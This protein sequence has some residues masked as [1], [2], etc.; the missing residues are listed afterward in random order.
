MIR[1]S[2]RR[3]RIS[4]GCKT[5]VPP[6]CRHVKKVLP[7][8]HPFLF[9]DKVVSFDAD[10]SAITCKKRFTHSE[11]FFPGHFPGKPIVPGGILIEAMAQA[12]ILLYAAIKP[13]LAAKRPEFYIGKVE[14]KFLKPVL[15]GDIM[16]I[17]VSKDILI[18]TGGIVRATG[19]VEN[20]TVA[21][22][23]IGFGVKL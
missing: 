11:Y 10:L 16:T 17:T 13:A 18:D 21:L 9:I 19:V 22:A 4:S 20:A 1:K 8:R 12:G 14:A 15:P 5:T 2:N 23:T 3:H 6:A 7:Q